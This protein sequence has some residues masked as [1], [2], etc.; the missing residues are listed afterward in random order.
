MR[1]LNPRDL[2]R[3]SGRDDF[4]A[5]VTSFR[6]EIDDPICGF[7][8]L[9]IMFDHHEGMS[10]VYQ[11]LEQPQQYGNVVEVQSRGWLVEDEEMVRALAAQVLS[12]VGYRVV[13]AANGN[14]AIGVARGHKGDID[15]V[16]TDAVMPEM[17]GMELVDR[18]QQLRPG[19]S[20]LMM[21]GYSRE[22]MT[23]SV[24]SPSVKLLQKP[25][26]PVDLC[27]KVREVLDG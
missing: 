4:T 21:S 27:R 5:A 13:D 8:H 1:L 11:A 16:L 6:S 23:G 19:I 22:A 20:V 26:T 18:L 24:L 17:S 14:E 2:L 7:D 15:L 9:H 10:A 25:F 3:R 12:N